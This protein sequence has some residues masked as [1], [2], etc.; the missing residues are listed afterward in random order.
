M[1]GEASSYLMQPLPVHASLALKVY[2]ISKHSL[3]AHSIRAV[4]KLF[5]SK[6]VGLDVFIFPESGRYTSAERPRPLSNIKI[7]FYSNDA[8][9]AEG[10]VKAT[11]RVFD[12]A[13]P[14]TARL[15]VAHELYH[16]ICMLLE[17]VRTKEW[18]DTVKSSEDECDAFAWSL[19]SEHNKFYLDKELT[20]KCAW[21]ET[22][23]TR[24]PIK[25]SEESVREWPL[26]FGLNEKEG[27]FLE[28]PSME[29]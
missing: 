12:I 17:F 24:G 13:N 22:V 28:F 21:G 10:R 29:L 5:E 4:K 23:F 2:E 19:C 15:C 27:F 11:I 16:L 1:R 8:V 9:F 14:Y 20:K 25:T 26:P 18:P 3:M 6:E 7:A